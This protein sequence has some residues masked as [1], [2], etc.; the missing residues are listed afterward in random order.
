LGAI[1]AEL[2]EQNLLL[3]G[4][5]FDEADRAASYLASGDAGTMRGG[6]GHF[7]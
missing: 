5:D 4:G 3:S 7:G 1:F 6:G 2:Q